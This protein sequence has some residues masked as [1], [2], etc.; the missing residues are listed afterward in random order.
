MSDDLEFE[1]GKAEIV[2]LGQ[3]FPLVSDKTEK[4]RDS[5]VRDARGMFELVYR[6]SV[7]LQVED[8]Q[9]PF[10]VELFPSRF[11]VAQTFTPLNPGV[12]YEITNEDFDPAQRIEKLVANMDRYQRWIEKDKEL[13][14]FAVSG[15]DNP[16]KPDPLHHEKYLR[17]VL[18]VPGGGF[19]G[20]PIES[21][22]ID[23]HFGSFYPIDTPR[24]AELS[25]P[26]GEIPA[27][28]ELKRKYGEDSPEYQFIGFI[29]SWYDLALP[30]DPEPLKTATGTFVLDIPAAS[31]R[32][33]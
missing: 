33:E 5:G 20:F 15:L 11:E 27:M 19:I 8:R 26:S 21:E 4:L 13:L 28:V 25:S 16:P 1:P 2:H 24:P 32:L 3:R 31:R 18:I 29:N 9:V 12:G 7:L 23:L 14:Q 10:Q 22:G 17:F 6:T 30:D